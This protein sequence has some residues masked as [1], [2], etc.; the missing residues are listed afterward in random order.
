MVREG[1]KLVGRTCADR[2]CLI[3]AIS[4]VKKNSYFDPVNEE[5]K[6]GNISAVFIKKKKSD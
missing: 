2:V 5:L 4:A 1:F 6:G 3:K